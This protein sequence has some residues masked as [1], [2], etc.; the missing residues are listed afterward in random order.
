[1]AD[2]T[3]ELPGSAVEG[4][5]THVE[6]HNA[7]VT[8][9]SEARAV[10]D[11]A[12]STIASLQGLLDGKA[13]GGHKHAAAD[14]TSGTFADARIPSLAIGKISG[15]QAALDGK[16]AN[17]DY[18]AASH[19]HT[20]EQVDGLQAALNAKANSAS[21]SAKADQSALEAL[22]TRVAALETPEA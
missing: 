11:A 1:M 4:A 19:T 21:L 13:D 12:E 18:A 7:I 16:Q 3:T 8:A 17:G 9:I 14:V 2:W 22:E 10:I 15:L 5:D 20:I 6:D